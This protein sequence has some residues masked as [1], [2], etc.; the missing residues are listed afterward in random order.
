MNNDKTGYLMKTIMTLTIEEEEKE[1]EEKGREIILRK[2]GAVDTLL[3]SED[4]IRHAN[5]ERR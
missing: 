2:V 1:E 3:M 4:T 5:A